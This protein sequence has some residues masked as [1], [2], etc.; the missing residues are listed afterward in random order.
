MFSDT[1]KSFIFIIK[2]VIK[3]NQHFMIFIKKVVSLQRL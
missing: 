2:N 1:Y 3:K